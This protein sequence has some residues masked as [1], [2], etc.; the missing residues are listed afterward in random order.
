[1]F[2]GHNTVGDRGLC[3]RDITLLVTVACVKEHNTASDRGLCSRDI[4][5]LVTSLCS[6]DIILLVTERVFRGYN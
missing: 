1:M 2:K 5:L 3:S 6:R 4:T